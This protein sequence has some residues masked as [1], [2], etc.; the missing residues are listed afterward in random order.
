M[1]EDSL[2][3]FGVPLNQHPVKLILQKACYVIQ[4]VGQLV[5]TQASCFLESLVCG[6]SI[7]KEIRDT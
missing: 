4:P 3:Q 2:F 6:P 5:L 7:G 1:G